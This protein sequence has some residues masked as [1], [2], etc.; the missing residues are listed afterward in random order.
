MGGCLGGMGSARQA[1]RGGAG[2]RSPRSV[3]P[4]A[5]AAP[6][7][8]PSR[9]PEEAEAPLRPA[10]EDVSFEIEPGQLVALVGHSGAGKTTTTYLIP[11]F[12]DPTSGRITLDGHDLRDLTLDSL[13]SQFGVVT[14]ESFLFHDTLRANLLYARPGRHRSRAHRRLP[15][16]EHPRPDHLPAPRATTRSSASGASASPGARSSASASP[17]RSSR[18]R[19]S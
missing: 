5:T 7:P 15:R 8:L 4:A 1:G 3:P 14:Q 9:T 19:A 13:A 11:R 16:G 17:G 6:A 18:T 2:A 10:L 12:Y